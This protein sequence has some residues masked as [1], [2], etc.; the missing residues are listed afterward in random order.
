MADCRTEDTDRCFE[1]CTL[2]AAV[3]SHVVSIKLGGCEI[4]TR[5]TKVPCP[6]TFDFDEIV[7]R[8]GSGSIKW[9][10]DEDDAVLPMWVAD[11][12][13]RTAPA[14]I[15]ALQ[16]RVAHGVFG[17]TKVRDEYYDAL[18]DWFGRRHGARIER[19]WV[20][21]TSGVVPAVVAV[22]RALTV[23]GD[24]VIVQPPVYN[25][26]FSSILTPGCEASLNVLL[27]RDGRYAIDFDDLERK[28]ADPKARVLLLCNPHNPVGRVWTRD[29]LTR[30]GEIC[31]R[32][33]VVVVSDEIHCDLVFPGHVHVPFGSISS[34]LLMRCVTCS[35]PSKAFNLAGLQI[36][37]IVAA[38]PE[39]R[40]RI[41]LALNVH[42]AREA[43]PFGV[44]AL[45]AAYT[46]GE[47]W[48]QALTRYL[49][50][51]RR[52]LND[53][54]SQRLPRARVVPQEATYLTWID[55]TQLDFSSGEIVS[56]LRKEGKLWVNDGALYGAAGEGFIRINIGCPAS[57][58]RDGLDRLGRVQL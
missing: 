18:I 16:Q 24:R 8:R 27:Y 13:F 56:R 11:M 2:Q 17:Y 19:D 31:L 36:A 22:L 32:H 41:E 7:Q 5:Q 3:S 15:E 52:L 58:L 48:L 35:S 47:A 53:L 30:V 34:E 20:L 42:E 54:L 28:A 43:N 51:N 21:Y 57:V 1:Y 29:E 37:N 38:D 45:I 6:M 14:V 12:D 55:C 44:E 40:G 46:K 49:D 9:D 39:I 4:R 25:A 33:D 50:E 26:F 23:P 10:T